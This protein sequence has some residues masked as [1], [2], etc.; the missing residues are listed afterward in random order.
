MIVPTPI[1]RLL[2]A[3]F[4]IRATLPD[5][6]AAC[7]IDNAKQA[8]CDVAAIVDGVKDLVGD[9]QATIFDNIIS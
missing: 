7:D 5:N 4:A 1:Q 8:L 6:I 2:A 9:E 3:L